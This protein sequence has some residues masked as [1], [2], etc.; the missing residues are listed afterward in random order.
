VGLEQWTGADRSPVND[1][2][3]II[4]KQEHP[5]HTVPLVNVHRNFYSRF[6]IIVIFT[7]NMCA[8]VIYSSSITVQNPTN[9]VRYLS[10]ITGIRVLILK[11]L[12]GDNST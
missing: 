10:I 3:L 9:T 11:Y 8:I 1:T 4:W 5:I 2:D 12:Y 7:Q 6:K